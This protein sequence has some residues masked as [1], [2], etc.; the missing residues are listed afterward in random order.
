[1]V[2]FQ[3]SEL[4]GSALLSMMLVEYIGHGWDLATATHQ[5]VPFDETEADAALAAVRGLLTPEFR[6]PDKAFGPEVIPPENA[7]SVDRLV[8]FLGRN[9]AVGSRQHRAG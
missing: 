3:G 9:P 7:G 2:R 1:M 4:P 5:P 8:A 6:G